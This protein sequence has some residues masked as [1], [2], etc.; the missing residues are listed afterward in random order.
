MTAGW[1]SYDTIA[2]AYE[3]LW[4][5]RF[6]TVAR[7]LLALGP[8]V[9]GLRVL[10]L[11][12]GTGAVAH[13]CRD[14]LPEMRHLIACDLSPTML[15]RVRLAL[16][17][18]PVVADLFRLPLR[19]AAF[20]L[21]T[22][23]CVLSH[24]HDHQTALREVLRVLTRPGTLLASSW[25]MPVSDSAAEAWGELLETVIGKGAAQQA[26]CE[27]SPLEAFFAVPEN[28]RGSLSAAGFGSVRIEE[29]GHASD[30]GVEE[31]V[32]ERSLNAPG[33]L[34]RQTLGK[35]G[36]QAFVARAEAEF[37]KRFGETIAF[38]RRVLLAAAT[39]A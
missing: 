17:F 35:A 12:A 3:R 14:A 36:W 7:Q 2:E 38:R 1:R 33:R 15:S 30:H 20:E 9:A 22:A 6:V 31:Y 26:M 34:A 23:N 18:H 28:V 16:P 10:D 29:I 5:R 19:D 39:V 8:S 24:V 21:V 11:G 27:V 13:A 4:H 37:R 32:A 25:V